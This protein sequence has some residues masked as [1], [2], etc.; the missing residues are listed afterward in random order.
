MRTFSYPASLL[1]LG[2]AA[3]AGSPAPHA[4]PPASKAPAAGLARHASAL[5]R[6]AE[7]RGAPQHVAAEEPKPA[8]SGAK[9]APE[10]APADKDARPRI[11]AL[12]EFAR[13]YKHASFEG[14]ALGR[15]R[16]GT[17][18]PLKSTKP[19]EGKGCGRGW[20]AVEPRGYVCLN[21][22]TTLD[23]DD[24]YYRALAGAAPGPEGV[25]HYRY[26]F[27][28]GA[29]MYSRV[30]T[31]EEAEQH[32]K[33]FGPRRS[34]VQLGEWGRG[35]EEL[36]VD[37]PIQATDPVP[38]IFAGGERHVG[39]GTRDTRRLVWRVIPNGSIL[40][41]ARAF[42][43]HGRVWLM[44]P[45]LMLVPAD[46]VRDIRRST[47]H[48]VMLGDGVELPLAWNRTKG[49]KPK[50]VRKD[51]EMVAVPGALAP[52]SWIMVSEDKLVDGGRTY[53]PVRGEADTFVDAADVTLTTRRKGPLPSGVSPG[54][55]WIE[56]KI[57]PGT[58]TAYEGDRPVRA[59]LFSPGKGGVPASPDEDHTKWAT[60]SIG[61]FP[62]EWKDHI[63]TMTNEHGEP[64][65]YWFADVPHIQ[66]LRAPLAMH[67][68]FW[69]EDFG[70]PKS[71]ECVNVSPEDG[72]WLF[73][74]TLPHL[75][76]G[77]GGIRPGDGNGKSTPV[78]VTAR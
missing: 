39:G 21:R 1:A 26:A 33:G 22:E 34:Y 32:E 11:G 61:Y 29:P 75:P 16:M 2:L 6:D 70:N 36:L 57:L 55:R 5:A 38:A 52:K 27:S 40:S 3:C 35:H 49:T 24:P 44:T 28:N 65:V 43:M 47:F 66:Y 73:D 67:V 77:W 12:S 76:E 46:R 9:S 53:L 37:H 72:R 23:L 63:A 17:S 42:E 41:Y 54:E 58:L 20:F 71:A 13:I 19:V 25:W 51:G 48:G 10:R 78:I 7:G 62:I 69:H 50:Y 15:L 14:L 45:D 74:W 59:T 31:D 4:P 18:V 30:P 56:A 8:A 60:T 68:A 64:K